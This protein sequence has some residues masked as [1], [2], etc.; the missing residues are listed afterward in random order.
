MNRFFDSDNYPFNAPLHQVHTFMACV[1]C[2]HLPKFSDFLNINE[3]SGSQTY[4]QYRDV[5]LYPI[6]D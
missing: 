3:Y 2:D 5:N 6:K 4:P 1:Q